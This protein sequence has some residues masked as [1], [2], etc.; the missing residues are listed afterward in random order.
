MDY[1]YVGS[2]VCFVLRHSYQS[3]SWNSGSTTYQLYDLGKAVD[4]CSLIPESV[5]YLIGL[6]NEECMS[7]G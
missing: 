4:F 1:T 3:L 5:D 2:P 7:Y 6:I